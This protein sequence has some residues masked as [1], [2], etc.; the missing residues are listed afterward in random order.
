MTGYFE[1]IRLFIMN[2]EFS[3]FFFC[4]FH[5]LDILIFDF[6]LLNGE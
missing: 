5:T 3:V 1:M 4:F 2:D 6:G